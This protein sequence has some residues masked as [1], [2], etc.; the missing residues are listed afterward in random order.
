MH[1]MTSLRRT[2]VH[3]G[4]Y[5]HLIPIYLHHPCYEVT[6]TDP[7][8]SDIPPERQTPSDIIRLVGKTPNEP[9]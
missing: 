4:R 3:L 7:P 5:L 9:A 2:P 6:P 8:T 1:A